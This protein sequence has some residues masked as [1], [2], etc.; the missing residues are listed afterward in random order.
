LRLPGVLST[1]SVAAFVDVKERS[2]AKS[3]GAATQ[4]PTGQPSKKF[5]TRENI[6]IVAAAVALVLLVAFVL[7]NSHTVKV[8]FVFFSARISLIWVLLIAAV[9]GAVVDRLVIMLRRRRKKAS[10]DP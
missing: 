1:G 3:T 4:G 2:M 9:L 8:G 6:R 10:A 7:A 5:L